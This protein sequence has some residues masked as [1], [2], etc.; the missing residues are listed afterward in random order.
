MGLNRD[1]I[2]LFVTREF[3]CRSFRHGEKFAMWVMYLLRTGELVQVR[4]VCLEL[5]VSTKDEELI[6][7]PLQ[8]RTVL[9]SI[10]YCEF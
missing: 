4:L 5:R 3:F 9:R 8:A 10:Y 6:L 7:R 1:K 2:I